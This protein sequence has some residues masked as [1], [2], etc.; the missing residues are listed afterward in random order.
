MVFIFRYITWDMCNSIIR[1]IC[2]TRYT[3]FSQQIAY[4]LHFYRDKSRYFLEAGV[5][6]TPG[7]NSGVNSGVSVNST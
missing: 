3:I 5:E 6:L 4:F 7:V 1:S 2:V